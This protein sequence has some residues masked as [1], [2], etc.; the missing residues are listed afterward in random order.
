MLPSGISLSQNY[1]NPFN[2]TTRI[3]YIIPEA[4]KVKL[5]VY[6]ILEMK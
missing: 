2:P 6:D 3:K 1:P 4:A 5:A